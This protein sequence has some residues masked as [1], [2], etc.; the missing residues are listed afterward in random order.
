MVQGNKKGKEEMKRKE[1]EKKKQGSR[2]GGDLASSI[3]SLIERHLVS[4]HEAYMMVEKD[5]KI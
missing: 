2:E 5:H 1:G 4:H 3:K